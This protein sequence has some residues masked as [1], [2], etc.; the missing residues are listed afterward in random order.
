MTIIFK[1]FS[2]IPL[3]SG[4]NA[5]YPLNKSSYNFSGRIH[6]DD[7]WSS[8]KPL[9]IYLH[10]S[11]AAGYTSNTDPFIT[12]LVNA[13]YGVFGIR[14]FNIAD[15]ST[16]VTPMGYGNVNSPMFMSF[17]IQQAWFVEAAIQ[18]A[19]AQFVNGADTSIK[20]S[21]VIYLVGYSVGGSAA[22]TWSSIAGLVGF[23][24]KTTI[25]GIVTF[26]AT[27]AGLGGKK[28]NNVNRNLAS[29][30]FMIQSIQHDII[31]CYNDLDDYAPPDY[32]RRLQYSVPR[33]R[34]GYFV[35]MGGVGHVYDT[36]LC[37]DVFNE[38][39]LDKPPKFNGNLII[40]I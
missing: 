29:I 12:G 7:S 14:Y 35:S 11:G 1:E 33:G 24:P 17:F 10:G 38:I 19:K 2:S 34:K 13:G 22:I 9:I 16:A 27:I 3:A 23:S 36:Q 26:G 6:Y 20:L 40:P 30:S 21:N 5:R 32:S 39:S 37:I 18:F 4:Y 25:K 31:Y 15:S 28:W 8:N